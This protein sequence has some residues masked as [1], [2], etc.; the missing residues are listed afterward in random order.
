M[1]PGGT[2]CRVD[3]FGP[4]GD[5]VLAL[6]TVSLN[7]REA[8]VNDWAIRD[9]KVHDRALPDLIARE[10]TLAVRTP[11]TNLPIKTQID[12]GTYLLTDKFFY[13]IPFELI[14]SLEI[15]D[16]HTRLEPLSEGDV[17]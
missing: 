13:D 10:F 1:P 12:L 15:S 5:K 11:W 2:P 14:Q 17:T 3:F 6:F 4:G 16:F 8:D 9:G 7:G